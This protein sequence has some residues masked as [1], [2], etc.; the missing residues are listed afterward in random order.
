MDRF[1]EDDAVLLR[2]IW[3]AARHGVALTIVHIV[4]LPDHLTSPSVFTTFPGEAERAARGRIEAA[5]LRQGIDPGGVEI[6]IEIGDP[7]IR[8]VE[9]CEKIRPMLVVMRAHHKPWLAKKR[10][11]STTEWVIAAGHAPVLI[12]R[13]SV[14]KPYD[15]VL[16]AVDGPDTVPSALSLVMALLPE[17]KVH[18][19]HA[20]ALPPQLE[21]AMLRAGLAHRE[22]TAHHDV[23]VRE[24]EARLG[25]L[26]AELVPQVMWQ[27]RRG[28][29]P[30]ELLHATRE[31]DAGLIVLGP[32]LPR[33][34]VTGSVTRRLL[35]DAGCDG[36]IARPL[37]AGLPDVPA[38]HEPAAAQTA[39]GAVM[40]G[41]ICFAHVL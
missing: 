26:A 23:L 21:Q 30:Q 29:P 18:M 24:A 25:Y 31:S 34:V 5:L 4:D 19:V 36:L 12:V 20:V 32:N 16:L 41:P 37:A 35:R 6:L 27:V 15:R 33:R 13:T 1:P 9:I 2:G 28:D 10:L 38:R 39:N 22:L 7:A 3:V 17:T 40:C 14:D 8:L 11:G